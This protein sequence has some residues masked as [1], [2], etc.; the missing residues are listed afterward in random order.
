MSFVDELRKAPE[1]KALQEEEQKKQAEKQKE[2]DWDYL[3]E[4]WC[5]EIRKKCREVALSG[6]TKCQ[7]SFSRFINYISKNYTPLRDNEKAWWDRLDSRIFCRVNP[8][9]ESRFAG[10]SE[11]DYQKMCIDIGNKLK[12]DGLEVEFERHQTQKYRLDY[13]RVQRSKFD[14]F[15]GGLSNLLLDTDYDTDASYERLGRVKDGY[16]YDLTVNISW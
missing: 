15:A 12:R 11:E 14:Q 8:R 7:V 16:W 3:V 2:K 10:L 13:V 9:S 1:K 4:K 6:E 5:I